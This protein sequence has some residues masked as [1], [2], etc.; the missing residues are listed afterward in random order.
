[1]LELA[2][3]SLIEYPK[4][5]GPMPCFAVV[6][7]ITN[8]KMNK[9]GK[10]QFMGALRHRDPMLCTQSALAQYFFWRWHI[11]GEQ[12]PSFRRKQD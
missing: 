1:M 12:L 6:V 3:M 10:K 4:V 8:G 2:D 11:S 7:Q 9:T 5:E